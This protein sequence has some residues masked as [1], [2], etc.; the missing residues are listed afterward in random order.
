MRSAGFK[1]GFWLSIFF[2]QLSFG[3]YYANSEFQKG[4]YFDPFQSQHSYFD[5]EIL[6]EWNAPAA[7][8]DLQAY[9]RMAY[10]LVEKGAIQNADGTPS[11]WVTP[12]YALFLAALYKILGYTYHVVPFANA[13][14]LTLAY[15]FLFLVTRTW[16]SLRAAAITLGL[17]LVNLRTSMFVGYVYSECLFFFLMGLVLWALANGKKGGSAFW[18]IVAGVAF[19]WAAL[20]R[21]VALAALPLI[22]MVAGRKISW[23]QAGLLGLLG[24]LPLSLWA[25]R[26]KALFGVPLISTNSSYAL[27]EGN[28]DFY[29]RFRFWDLYA[30]SYQVKPYENPSV[31]HPN[32]EA[33]GA[34]RVQAGFEEWRAANTGFYWW[35][36]AFPAALAGLLVSRGRS[37]L[38]ASLLALGG[39]ALLALPALAVV[40]SSLRYQIPA[41]LL[42]SPAAALFYEWLAGRFHRSR[43]EIFRRIARGPQSWAR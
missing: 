24:I 14:L 41:Q 43:F 23:R 2:L 36:V 39:I 42:L 5:S 29:R 21:P 8:G 16:L 22:S 28:Q 32:P 40:G 9:N 31:L 20:T 27:A 3:Y 37:R 6:K 10:S 38:A 26:N 4:K 18:I 13:A 30:S 35:L 1:L 12:G 7:E 17:L 11:A 33:E 34:L 25:A 19:G 15:C